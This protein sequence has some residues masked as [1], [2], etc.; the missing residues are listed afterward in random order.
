MMNDHH[1]V[2]RF[3]L[4]LKVPG[5]HAREWILEHVWK[6]SGDNHDVVE[7]YY[8][9]VPDHPE[10]HDTEA[11]FAKGNSTE[12]L[13]RFERLT[14]VGGVPQTRMTYTQRV[15]LGG[16]VPNWVAHS[17]GLERLLVV[18]NRRMFFDKSA[19]IDAA[20][21]LRLASMIRAHE[22]EY[23]EVERR[24]IEAGHDR[25][26]MFEQMKTKLLKM[27]SPS[28]KAKVAFADNNSHAWG[29]ATTT[30]RAE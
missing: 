24:I 22:G 16:A 30:A 26:K 3:V 28:T 15:G 9:H 18:S 27:E 7:T 1:G 29:W 11:M 20:S 12:M 23:T 10:Y 17:R 21:S 13:V 5:F 25:L 6:F 2:Y 14:G 4:D 19:E 8:E